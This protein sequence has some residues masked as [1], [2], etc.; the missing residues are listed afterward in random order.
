MPITLAMAKYGKENFR[1]EQIDTAASVEEANEKEVSWGK[2]YN[3]FSPHGYNLRTGGRKFAG[4]SDSTKLKIGLANKGK[5]A[6]AETILKL[7]N[8]HLGI[9][10]TEEAKRKLSL[11]N[12]GREPHPNCI[13]AKKQKIHKKY[14]LLSPEGVELEVEN[15]REFCKKLELSAPRMSNLVTGKI[16]E[17]RGW[18]FVKDCGYLWEILG[19]RRH[20]LKNNLQSGKIWQ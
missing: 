14:I 8:S 17:H 1:I 10:Q 16:A 6:S 3:T 7:R 4:L 18:R 13:A 11:F 12:K 20:P 2:A 9:K 5:K 19:S 15:M